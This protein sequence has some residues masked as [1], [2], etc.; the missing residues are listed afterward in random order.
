MNLQFNL[1]LATRPW[2]RRVRNF[3]LREKY[4]KI[5][6]S[7]FSVKVG[8]R[9]VLMLTP[10]HGNLGDQ[11]IAIGE[12]KL[13]EELCPND[14]IIEIPEC[15]YEACRCELVKLITKEDVILI[16]GGGF[17]GNLYPQSHDLR[18]EIIQ[19]YIDNEIICMPT[20]IY[21]T[22]DGCG[23]E[24]LQKDKSAFEEHRK[25]TVIARDETSFT[26]AKKEFEKTKLVLSPDCALALYSDNLGQR[27]ERSGVVFIM[28]QDKEKALENKCL[29]KLL[30]YLPSG[31]E[32]KVIDNICKKG[33]EAKTR[34]N[35][36]IR[37]LSRIRCARLVITDRFHGVIFAVMTHTPVIAYSS[38]DTKIPAGIKWF[39]KIDPVYLAQKDENIEKVLNC[40]LDGC[41]KFDD[42][43]QI[44]KVLFNTIGKEL[45]VNSGVCSSVIEK[46]AANEYD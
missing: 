30:Q 18:R 14:H 41:F 10:T 45:S 3:F 1:K 5:L 8:R 6:K 4:L 21:Y 26:F 38:L 2:R 46:A 12:I 32:Y 20:S 34:M 25:L 13:L 40:Y 9:F 23:R 37:H 43:E 36:V 19:T 22:N 16:H 42:V 15:I 44:K 24:C 17:F 29:D 28:R 11:A 33:F 35:A 7:Q 27:E 39:D 31:T